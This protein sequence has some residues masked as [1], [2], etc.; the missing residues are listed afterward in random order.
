M[1]RYVV[2]RTEGSERLISSLLLSHGRLTPGN[3]RN[4]MLHAR[5]ESG[6]EHPVLNVL[7]SFFPMVAR[8]HAPFFLSLINQLNY[9]LDRSR[10]QRACFH[11]FVTADEFQ[12]SSKIESLLVRR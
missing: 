5:V 4:P 10:T 7:S 8:L 9:S 2:Q 11:Q 3:E 1:L 12:L 6:E